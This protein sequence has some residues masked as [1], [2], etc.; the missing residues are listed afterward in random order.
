MHRVFMPRTFYY[1][2][3]FDWLFSYLSRQFIPYNKSHYYADKTNPEQGNCVVD[4]CLMQ[5]AQCFSEYKM[6]CRFFI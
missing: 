1:T 3:P 6:S 4:H 2:I 5:M